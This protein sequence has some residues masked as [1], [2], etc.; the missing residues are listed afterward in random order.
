MRCKYDPFKPHIIWHGQSVPSAAR[1]LPVWRR[2]RN[3]VRISQARIEKIPTSQASHFV[4]CKDDILGG[5]STDF[6]SSE[7][8]GFLQDKSPRALAS[9][10]PQEALRA[11]FVPPWTPPH[12]ALL[13]SRTNASACTED[14]LLNRYL[15]PSLR[16]TMHR[17][18]PLSTS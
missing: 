16:F 7:T 8:P 13:G 9:R 15:S 18:I 3:S 17:Y 5:N 2:K 11:R 4:G 14:M 12:K 10:D 6:L 1:T